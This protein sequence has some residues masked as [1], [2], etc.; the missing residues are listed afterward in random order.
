MNIARFLDRFFFRRISASGFGLMRIAWAAT[1]LIFLLFQWSDVGFFFSDA[2]IIPSDLFSV[3]FRGEYRFTL[4]DTYTT[5]V[6][7]FGLYLLL[8]GVL[9]TTMI[10]YRTRFSTVVTA[11]LLFSFHE[12][13]LLPLSGGDTVLRNLGF[14][15]MIAPEI[16][17]FSLDRAWKQWKVWEET[18]ELLAPLTM[19]IWPWRLLLW[20]FIIIYIASGIDKSTGTMWWDGTAVA[21]ALHHTHFARWPMRVMD[22]VS[23]ASPVLCSATLV[24][25]FGWLL[26]LVP[27]SLAAE[28]PQY[29]KRHAVRRSLLL[30]GVLF[31]GAIFIL[32]DVASFSVAMLSGYLGLLLTEDFTDLRKWI[33]DPGKGKK[34]TFRQGS[35]QER[36]K[37]NIAVLYDA[38]CHLCRRSMFVLLLCDHLHRLRAVNFR[39]AMLRK[40]Y[41]PDIP[42]K[43]LDRSMHIKIQASSFS[44]FD[45]FRKIANHLP[46]LWPLVPLLY[47]PGIPPLGRRIYRYIAE[48]RNRCADGYCVHEPHT[49]H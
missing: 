37:G 35:G 44:G 46:A 32:M 5:P 33:N 12:R 41:A 9:I 17:A 10:G 3:A 34:A 38:A 30:G 39:D 42:L 2:G 43:D 16:R 31:H 7:V 6:A 8:L 45:A 28:L 27:E 19:P 48:N 25:E 13:N 1:A 49:N 24:F 23:I 36:Q 29:M 18:K 26:M 47:I 40:K 4:L 21:S 14:I 22:I 15:L 11:L 20:Q